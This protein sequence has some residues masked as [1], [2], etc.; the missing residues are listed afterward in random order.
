[1]T[2]SW[3]AE[4]WGKEA[5]ENR[6]FLK[7]IQRRILAVAPGTWK[8]RESL[9]SLW[10][11]T[12]GL[13]QLLGIQPRGPGGRFQRLS[14]YGPRR[15]R[16]SILALEAAKGNN[17]QGGASRVQSASIQGR[18]FTARAG[19]PQSLTWRTSRCSRLVTK[20]GSY[21][22]LFHSRHSDPVPPTVDRVSRVWGWHVFW[23]TSG[24]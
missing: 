3:K 1:M 21:A 14:L 15:V 12:Q 24:P 6:Q 4:A 23:A 20:W 22:R 18:P 5:K 9:L 2:F 16:F 7:Y 19:G 13:K 11:W 17:E 8:Q 10:V